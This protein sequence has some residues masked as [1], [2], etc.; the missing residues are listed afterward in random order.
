MKN[1]LAASTEEEN[2]IDR[3]EEIENSSRENI[4]HGSMPIM[5]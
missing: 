2:K 4:S 5:Q 3:I 1:Q